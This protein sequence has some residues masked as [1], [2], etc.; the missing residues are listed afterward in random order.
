MRDVSSK[1]S[2]HFSGI[3][4]AL[5]PPPNAGARGS[6]SGASPSRA[7]HSGPLRGTAAA[8]GFCGGALGG[9]S[10]VGG[11][12]Y[13]GSAAAA[14]AA[15]LE[16]TGVPDRELFSASSVGAGVGPGR[17]TFVF[18][19]ASPSTF[20]PRFS[21]PPSST[22]RTPFLPGVQGNPIRLARDL[23]SGSAPGWRF[24]SIE[25][26]ALT[27][28]RSLSLGQIRALVLVL[29]MHM[30]RKDIVRAAM[31]STANLVRVRSVVR[32]G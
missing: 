22:T 29:Q 30:G 19:I 8:G 11:G 5:P 3:P 26:S 6:A 28:C 9:G 10:G 17:V 7:G 13:G 4:P 12:T 24:W 14:A 18:R 27:A 15:G 2:R 32:V 1:V 21:P 20:R 25:C 16:G 23:G 31:R